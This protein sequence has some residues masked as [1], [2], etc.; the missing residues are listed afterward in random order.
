MGIAAG[1]YVIIGNQKTF[2]YA[3]VYEPYGHFYM[4]FTDRGVFRQDKIN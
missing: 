1:Q 3:V 4:I 2:V